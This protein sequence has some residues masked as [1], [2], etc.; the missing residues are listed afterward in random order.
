MNYNEVIINV[1][2]EYK[3]FK[4]GS[5]FFFS[6]NL[7]LISGINGAGKSQLL[8]SIQ[9]G[10]SEIY[11][12]NKRIFLNNIIKYSFKDNISLPNFGYYD[13]ESVKQYNQ[14]ILNI[15]H[16]Y[17]SLYTSY[18]SIKTSNPQNIQVMLG[19]ERGMTEDNYYENN[20]NSS[21]S[22][23]NPNNH[24]SSI[25]KNISKNSIKEIID[26]LKT[27]HPTDFFEI[28]DSEVLK[29]IPIDFILRFEREEIDD[30]T[31]IFSES[32]R[33]REIIKGKYAMIPDTFNNKEWLKTAP[34]TEINELF[35]KLNFNYR[36]P[37]DFEYNIPFLKEEP[38][39][40][41]FENDI[42]DL[43]KKRSINDLSD[44][45]KSILRLVITTYDR[46]NDNVTKLLLLDEYDAVLNPSLI[47]NYY[48]V[49]KE[50]YINKGI[51]VML[52][53]HSS[54]TIA[55]AP[56]ETS[57]YEIFRQENESPKI[58]KVSSEEYSDLRLI[59]K[60][61]DKI[62]NSN[63]RL[64]ELD[65]EVEKLKEIINTFEKPLII[66][67]GKT[68]WKH[69]KNAKEKLKNNDEY[70]FYTY[71]EDMGDITLESVALFQS[72][73]SNQNK[74]IFIFD[75]D[76]TKIIPK[77]TEPGKNF[78]NWGNNVYSFVIPKPQIRN[79]EDLISIEHYYPD[80]IL[81]KEIECE[82]RIIR[83]LYC[84]NDFMTTANS[85]DLTKRCNKKDFCGEMK[86]HVMSGC[87]QEK[88]YDIGN[89]DNKS[90][91]Y[92]LTK[93]DFFEKIILSNDDIDL[94][95]FTLILD[96]IKEIIEL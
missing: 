86:L 18:Q 63:E 22:I 90:T 81:K 47:N 37:D 73:I 5:T 85:I 14:I 52:T 84:G 20:L 87:D 80:N 56:E 83:R 11:I 27:V 53:T 41:A 29:C 55:L 39:L 93:N 1:I 82:D 69:I 94:S 21:I 36:F 74:R 66:T 71:E 30:I 4:A 48:T 33:T 23:R 77:V 89:E 65:N 88:V 68:D 64:S 13:Y 54:A 70:D 7:I 35:A 25:S 8:E 95:K 42:L 67:E 72:K 6:G 50:Y 2:N 12:N 78:K 44:G 75:S 38:Q 31:R 16:N 92:A 60:Y 49:I 91:N 43:N 34:W 59:K 32:C 17:K 3:S 10:N 15:Y 79:N 40:Y 51:V 28:S 58:I 96:I 45:E 61:Y 26:T 46:K 62:S 19:I 57:F 76:N 24:N 9:N